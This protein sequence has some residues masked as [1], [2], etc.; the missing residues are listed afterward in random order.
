MVQAIGFIFNGQGGARLSTQLGIEVSRPSII[1]S[2]YLVPAPA[3]GQV[4]EV[5]IDDFAWK[6]GKRYG[7]IILD[8]K[9]HK[10]LDLLSDREAESVRTWLLVHPEEAIVSRDRGGAYA[11]GAATEDPG[12]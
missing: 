1:T 11:D 6:R 10:I 4:K 12:R 3:I 9:T 8:L 2:L 5:D 7:T